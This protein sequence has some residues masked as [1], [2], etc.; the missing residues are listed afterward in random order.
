MSFGY[1][2]TIEAGGGGAILTDD[3]ALAREL[4]LRASSFR[5]LDDLANRAETEFMLFERE[6]RNTPPQKIGLSAQE[7][8]KMLIARVPECRFGFPESLLQPLASAI[9]TLPDKLDV[10][11]NQVEMWNRFLAPFNDH[12]IPPE[13]DCEVP[14]RLIRRAPDI[15]NKLVIALRNLD[16]DAGTNFPPLTTSFPS[17]VSNQRYEGAEQWGSEVL[18]L[19]LSSDYDASRMKRVAEAI[20][21]FLSDP[22]E[23][24]P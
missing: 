5:P 22:Q 1:A 4:R 8:E 19:W 17:L 18:N 13:F 21:V 11:R 15:R 20:E 6:L 16:F 24:A 9:D 3:G 23:S 14:W 2:K 12:L 10:K 7:R